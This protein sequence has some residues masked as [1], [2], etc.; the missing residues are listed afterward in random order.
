M[1]LITIIF[2]NK[3]IY[4]YINILEIMYQNLTRKDLMQNCV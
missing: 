4:T 2:I 3:Y 1:P